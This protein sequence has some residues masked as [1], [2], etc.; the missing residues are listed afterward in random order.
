MWIFE[1]FVCMKSNKIQNLIISN[2]NLNFSYKLS[3]ACLYKYENMLGEKNLSVFSFT[4][5]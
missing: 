1:E 3:L 4:L 2:F 5:I